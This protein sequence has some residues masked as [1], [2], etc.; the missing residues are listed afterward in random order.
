MLRTIERALAVLEMVASADQ[1]P[2]VRAVSESLGHNVSSTYNIVNTLVSAGY[3]VRS[4]TGGLYLGGRVAYL[5][6]GF[7]RSRSAELIRPIVERVGVSSGETVYLTRLI[8]PRVAIEL[9]FE[10]R[11]SLRVGV[12]DVGFSGSEE[13]RASGKSVMA[14][15]SEEQCL[16][17][18]RANYP[19]AGTASISRRFRALGP[20]LAAISEKGFAFDDEAFEPGVCCLAAPYFGPDGEVAGSLT[21]SAPS[22][23]VDNLRGTVKSLVIS[24]AAEISAILGAPAANPVR[25]SRHLELRAREASGALA[26]GRG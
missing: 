13:Q 14:F 16:Q 22:L 5:A 10:G 3:L 23:R 18:L 2:S 7:E 24:A 4:S 17:I 19:E 25:H 20:E 26:A 8:G 9:T 21:V 15:L 6:K 11:G 12:L 1:P